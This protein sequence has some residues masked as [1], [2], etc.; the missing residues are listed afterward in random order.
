[1][2]CTGAGRDVRTLAL[3]V[4]NTAGPAVGRAQSTR[5]RAIAQWS[6]DL[7]RGRPDCVSDATE[8]QKR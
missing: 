3:Q 6:E 4:C 7:I 1:M 2:A 5:N 8:A